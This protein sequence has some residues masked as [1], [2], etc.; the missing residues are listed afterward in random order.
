MGW[1]FSGYD[2]NTAPFLTVSIVIHLCIL[3]AP[4]RLF[5]MTN[6]RI[7]RT[8][9]SHNF[10]GA[11]DNT[12]MGISWPFACLLRYKKTPHHVHLRGVEIEGYALTRT[13]S[14]TYPCP[15]GDRFRITLEDLCG[16]ACEDIATC[17]CALSVSRLSEEENLPN[18]HQKRSEEE[19]DRKAR[20]FRS[21][22]RELFVERPPSRRFHS[23][24]LSVQYWHWNERHQKKGRRIQYCH[25][26]VKKH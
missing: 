4:P 11:A 7:I 1:K 13:T 3:K 5:L 9:V 18:F 16:T 8:R 26:R 17:H 6:R 2:S 19:E 25:L 21:S 22:V 15:C 20:V 24:H 14:Y 10:R 12:Q 23:C